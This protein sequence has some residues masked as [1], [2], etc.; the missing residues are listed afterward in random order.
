VWLGQNFYV[1]AS[2]N[3]VVTSKSVEAWVRLLI[4]PSCISGTHGLHHVEPETSNKANSSHQST[5]RRARLWASGQY[6]VV[7]GD[8]LSSPLPF[9]FHHV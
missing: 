8:L 7:I 4:L 5:R 3:E 1:D 6:D 2:L 9:S